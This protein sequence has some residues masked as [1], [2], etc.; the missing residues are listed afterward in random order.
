M[1]CVKW[2]I[3]GHHAFGW[4]RTAP[5]GTHD[6]HALMEEGMEVVF[7][8]F[9]TVS[10]Q[11]VELTVHMEAP[12]NV[13]SV[14]AATVCVYATHGMLWVR[15]AHVPH[16]GH[17][18]PQQIWR[19]FSDELLH[20]IHHQRIDDPRL[21]NMIRPPGENVAPFAMAVSAASDVEALVS[22]AEARI[23]PALSPVARWMR[24]PHVCD[25][26]RR[27]MQ[28][29]DRKTGQ[30]L[31]SWDRTAYHRIPQHAFAEVGAPKPEQQMTTSRYPSTAQQFSNCLRVY[32]LCGPDDAAIPYAFPVLADVWDDL[33]ADHRAGVDVGPKLQLMLARQAAA[34][35][36]AGAF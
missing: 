24:G 17:A 11:P 8:R 29:L 6:L 33:K 3:G 16:R 10:A 35:T 26:S 2:K 15:D 25:P 18:A 13:T 21:F 20:R 9:L 4:V 32:D 19:G 14:G 27:L 34:D 7:R 22:A 1:P 28:V 12:E 5:D 31:L 36:V 23:D 30:D